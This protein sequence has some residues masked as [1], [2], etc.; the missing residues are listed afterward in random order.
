MLWLI[1]EEYFNQNVR[2]T[3]FLKYLKWYV[4]VISVSLLAL[5]VYF[6]IKFFFL[7][8]GWFL[9]VSC[10]FAAGTGLYFGNEVEKSKLKNIGN[11]EDVFDH[12]MISIR[13]ILNKRDINKIEQIELLINQINEEVSELKFSEKVLKPI[14]K[15]STVLIIPIITILTKELLNYNDMGI[16]SVILVILLCLMVVGIFYMIKP[17]LEQILD[18]PYRKMR[19]LKRVLEDVKMLDFLK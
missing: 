15:I 3:F 4:W 7:P 11:K 1:Y 13:T 16:Y 5:T 12:D 14:S 18:T 2:N 6:S 9:L 19:E 17:L 8:N 10:V